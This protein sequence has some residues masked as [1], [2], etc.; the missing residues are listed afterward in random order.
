MHKW[1][2]IGELLREFGLINA[3][4]LEAG[5]QY[6]KGDIK[7]FAQHPVYILHADPPEFDKRLTQSDARLPDQ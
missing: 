6:H 5:L 3:D 4:D 7:L 1:K 2:S